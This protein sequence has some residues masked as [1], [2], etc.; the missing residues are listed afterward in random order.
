M[1]EQRSI[2]I[3]A[4]ALALLSA[5]GLLI[6]YSWHAPPLPGSPGPWANFIPLLFGIA[7]VVA[8]PPL[9][10]HRRTWLVGYLV[11]GFAVVVGTVLM[12]YYDVSTWH[13]LP[14]P[15]DL[16]LHSN[17]SS[18]LILMAKL[19][20]GQRVLLHYRPN[21]AGR[22]FTGSWWTR[23]FLYVAAVFA[24]GALIGRILS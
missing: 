15:A 19:P 3:E 12:A 5:G 17:L 24:A 21:G 11:N 18:I 16:L 14:G 9:V 10:S 4:A 7:G 2:R 22:M 6:H 20:V 8:V 13:T 1:T 23:H